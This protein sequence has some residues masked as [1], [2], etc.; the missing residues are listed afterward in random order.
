MIFPLNYLFGIQYLPLIT[1][2]PYFSADEREVSQF[3]SSFQGKGLIEAQEL[4]SKRYKKWIFGHRFDVKQGKRRSSLGNN[5]LGILFIENLYTNLGS[6]FIG[7]RS[8]FETGPLM[9]QFKTRDLKFS[10]TY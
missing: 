5:C 7:K 1:D 4:L 8:G 3:Q 10:Y 2:K 9:R 6:E